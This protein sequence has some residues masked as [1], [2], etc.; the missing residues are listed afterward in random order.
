MKIRWFIFTLLIFLVAMTVQAQT[1]PTPTATPENPN[2]TITWPPPVYVL[3]GQ[4][5]IRG[6]ANLPN[7]SGYFIE[8][9]PLG[10]DL[11]PTAPDA[12][13]L[14]ATLPNKA[15]I[16]DDVLGT[17]DTATVPDGI[18]ELRLT[19][20]VTGGQPVS[21]LISPVRVENNPP[22]FAQ[23]PTQAATEAVLPTATLQA[24]LTATTDP[25]PRVTARLSANVRRGDSVIY[26]AIGALQKGESAPIV[27]ISSFGTGWYLIQ[28][29][30]GG[31]GWISNTVVDVS[32][33]L[34]NVPSVQPPPPPTPTPI[35]A[36]PT[37][38]AQANLVA[39][40]F[41]FDPGSPKCSQTFNIYLD[42]ANLGTAANASSGT[43][44]VQDF[45]VADGSLQQQTVGGFGIIQPGQT[46]N[47]GPIPLTVS[48]FYNEQHRIVMNVD[49]LN[50]VPETNE[51]DNT[52][53]AVYTLEKGGCP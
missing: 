16:Q 20:N 44:S 51:G 18:Y 49:S 48:T 45:R 19:V 33:D 3:R 9:R 30:T 39:G 53:V 17:W 35:P 8:Y 28:L 47:V 26:D 36:T 40:N 6:S 27:G 7:M 31:R 52:R 10:S 29:P 15:A 12:P 13:W 5:Q 37:P 32:G 1:S 41:R 50:Q 11:N 21:A 2:A 34:S 24:A 14:P 23:I 25:T 42:V 22:P 4:F 38:T 43:I 46:I